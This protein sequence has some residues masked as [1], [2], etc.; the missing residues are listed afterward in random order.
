[1]L[2]CVTFG[3]I[4][5]G[6]QVAS[7]NPLTDLQLPAGR[8]PGR[9][10]SVARAVTE[11][12]GGGGVAELVVAA[13]FVQP[14]FRKNIANVTTAVLDDGFMVEVLY[15]REPANTASSECIGLSWARRSASPWPKEAE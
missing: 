3:F 1:M 7:G 11:G 6:V 9:L 12:P 15:T 8:C 2:L 10:G 4:S 14:A 5:P 13:R